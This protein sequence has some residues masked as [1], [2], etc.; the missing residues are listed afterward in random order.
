MPTKAELEREVRKLRRQVAEFER[1]RDSSLHTK[2]EY[3]KRQYNIL[4]QRCT[5]LELMVEEANAARQAAEM[6]AKEAQTIGD[7]RLNRR[8]SQIREEI[9][10]AH[11][12]ESDAQVDLIGMLKLKLTKVSGDY[13]VTDTHA[14]TGVSYK[15]PAYPHGQGLDAHS[16]TVSRE[17]S[18]SYVGSSVSER[19]R[20]KSHSSRLPVPSDESGVSDGMPKS[21][22]PQLPMFGSKGQDD[23][24]A[25]D[26]WLRKLDR[27]AAL[28]KWSPRE[29]LLQFELR[30]TGKAEQLYEVL[31]TD[32]KN[33]PDTA[34]AALR[35]RIHPVRQDALASAQLMRRNNNGRNLWIIMPKPLK[36]YLIRAMVCDMGW[37][38]LLKQP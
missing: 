5:E 35:A 11:K 1:S 14:Y 19:T 23:G 7:E 25:L 20:I 38:Q 27:H 21:G 33:S 16:G 37:I 13:S 15:S 29:K 4:E 10:S 9:E 6:A 12:R 3:L 18:P 2:L 34:I 31:P 17:V 24:D 36:L 22:L 8:V 30:L 28:Q 26:R 32:V